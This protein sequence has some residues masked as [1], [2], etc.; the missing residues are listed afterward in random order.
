MSRHSAMIDVLTEIWGG[1]DPN[2]EWRKVVKQAIEE[3]RA[4]EAGPEP[5]GYISPLQVPLIVDPDEES[6]AYIPMRKTAGGN[7]TLAL[8]TAPVAAAQ[9][10]AQPVVDEWRKLAMQFGS[11]RMAAMWHL[12]TL[13][14]D[15]T[16][17]ADAARAF[18]AASPQE[19]AQPVAVPKPLT[20]EQLY[21]NDE[22]MSLNADLGWHMDTIRMFA[23]AIERAHGIA[24]QP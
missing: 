19:Q 10:V 14:K 6:G 1:L 15:P 8:H 4:V 21:A 7:F 24:G 16:A 18:I 3:L 9:P 5:I 12:K 20:D 22:I 17:H 23:R 13:L 11:Q 2:G